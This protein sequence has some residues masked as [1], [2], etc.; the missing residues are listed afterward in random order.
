[1][2]RHLTMQFLAAGTAIVFLCVTLG[3]NILNFSTDSTLLLAKRSEHIF[4]MAPGTKLYADETSPLYLEPYR[5]EDTE[6]AAWKWAS[7][8][9][10]K[11]SSLISSKSS[12]SIHAVTETSAGKQAN[13]RTSKLAQVSSGADPCPWYGCADGSHADFSDHPQSLKVVKSKP[14]ETKKPE[15]HVAKAK[16]QVGQNQNLL[17]HGY[18]TSNAFTV[19]PLTAE[20]NQFYGGSPKHFGSSR[21]VTSRS[22]FVDG[23]QAYSTDMAPAYDQDDLTSF[24]S[25]PLASPSSP[26]SRIALAQPA[27]DGT[28]SQN[29]FRLPF[30]PPVS[31]PAFS[32]PRLMSAGAA[33]GLRPCPAGATS[34]TACR[35]ASRRPP[36][37]SPPAPHRPPTPVVPRNE[38]AAG[39]PSRRWTRRSRTTAAST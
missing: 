6:K 34:S 18:G 31:P 16:S 30:S 23:S 32:R 3:T 22:G 38:S 37:S 10:S 4:E 9:R 25:L 36:P 19:H 26:E 27:G 24:D 14:T 29:I 17:A 21:P 11:R 33:A 39:R 1:M 7:D 2:S 20:K 15:K 5:H 28:L 35:A 13:L 12:A 8:V